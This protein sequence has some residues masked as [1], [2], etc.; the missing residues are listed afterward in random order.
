MRR[1][2]EAALAVDVAGELAE[3]HAV[4]DGQRHVVGVGLVAG[5]GDGALHCDAAD[6]V[7]AVEDDDF[8]L[9]AELLFGGG[10]FEEVA[11]C[12]FVGVEADSC[13]LQV[14]DDGVEVFEA[15]RAWGGVSAGLG[16]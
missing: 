13:V 14:D 2:G 1:A 12:G 7:G 9:V 3:G 16:P 15:C 10:G 4:A 6:E 5:V 11:D 8:E